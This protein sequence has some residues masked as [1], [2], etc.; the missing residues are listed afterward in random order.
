VQVGTATFWNPEAPI[1]IA[2]QL[3]KLLPELG[4]DRVGELVGTLKQ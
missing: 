2:R 1:E 4:V 3:E